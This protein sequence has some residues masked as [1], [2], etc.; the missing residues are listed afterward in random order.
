MFDMLTVEPNVTVCLSAKIKSLSFPPLVIVPLNVREC[1]SLSK[2]NL[3]DVSSES[4]R[5]LELEKVIELS[6]GVANKLINQEEYLSLI[7]I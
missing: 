7:H 5:V 4:V 1:P 2:I 6:G 3:S